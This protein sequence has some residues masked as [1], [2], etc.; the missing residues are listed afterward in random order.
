MIGVR[1]GL[2]VLAGALALPMGLV[3]PA[4]ASA[5]ASASA[6]SN[7]G[8]AAGDAVVAVGRQDT[9][10]PVRIV[11]GANS[12]GA[13]NRVQL[14]DSGMDLTDVAV[15]FPRIGGPGGT[16][17]LSTVG[18]LE[19]PACSPLRWSAVKSDE[20]VVLRCGT[21]ALETATVHVSFTRAKRPTGSFA[22]AYANRP[23]TRSYV[24]D[25][26]YQFGTSGKPMTMTR[27]ARGQYQVR[28]PHVQTAHGVVQVT[29]VGPDLKTCRVVSWKPA[30]KAAV[31]DQLVRVTCGPRWSAPQDNAFTLSYSASQNLLGMNGTPSGWVHETTPGARSSSPAQWS[32][33]GAHVKVARTGKAHYVISGAGFKVGVTCTAAPD[34]P[35]PTPFIVQWVGSFVQLT[36]AGASENVC[37]L[38]S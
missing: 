36:N 35:A 37:S 28:V 26:T 17:T 7:P 15:V 23:S 14:V 25:R 27:L 38:T 10:P 5:S 33:T 22:Y 8:A 12:T 30:T 2:T 29:A 20:R 24:P 21:N 1:A 18:D 16:V 31:S 3:Q 34:L 9:G 11:H 32:S 13:A 6:A 4:S 19:P